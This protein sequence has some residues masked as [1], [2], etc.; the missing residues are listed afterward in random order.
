MKATSRILINAL[1]SYGA[2]G[3]SIAVNILLIPFVIHHLGKEVFGLVAVV[4]SIQIIIRL[5]GSGMAQAMGRYFALNYANEDT[6]GIHKYYTNSVAITAGLLTPLVVLLAVAIV[7]FVVPI[8]NVP[9]EQR[10]AFTGLFILLSAFSI[11]QIWSAPYLAIC[12]SVQKFYLQHLCLIISQL[13]YAGILIALLPSKPSLIVYGSAYLTG[14][15]VR[16]VLLYIIGKR[17]FSYCKFRLKLIN[18]KKIR[19]IFSVSIQ[20][21]L[22]AF[23][24]NTYT[25]VNQIIVNIFLGPVYNT[26]LAVCL[27]WQNLTWQ[28]FNAVGSVIAPQITTYQAKEQ[29]EPIGNALC[30]VTKYSAM[31]S[32]PLCTSLAILTLP[33]FYLW[34]GEGYEISIEIMPWYALSLLFFGCQVAPALMLI[35]LGKNRLPST[36]APIIAGCNLAVVLIFVGFYGYGLRAIAIT[37][38][39]CTFIRL[40][41]FQTWYVARQCRISLREYLT[42]GYMKPLLSF[43]PS[44][45]ILLWAKE[46][47]SDW[48][49]PVLTAVVGAATV[50]YIPICWFAALDAWDRN[51]VKSH[52]GLLKNKLHR[53]QH[54]ITQITQESDK[55]FYDT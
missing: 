28:I 46:Q 41:L 1:S 48:S 10:F 40:G 38:F 21:F 52:L 2:L 34:L 11:A 8:C 6:E 44:V 25:Q 49:L 4:L 54:K 50:V 17:I 19:D 55:G 47:I 3:F 23:S 36:L 16:L 30:R 32:F 12:A 15:T 9:V 42:I 18:F 43:L 22:P 39:V 14:A 37:M 35:A 27:I 20:A 33:I 31:I 51:L 26:Y 24:S 53:R 13:V 7:L 29:W 45:I 5:A